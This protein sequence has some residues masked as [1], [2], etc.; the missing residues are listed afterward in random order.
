MPAKFQKTIDCTLNGLTKI[1]CFLD[2]ILK[3][4]RGRIEVHLHLVRKCL[5]KLDE[6]DLRVNI[7]KSHFAKDQIQWL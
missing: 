4:G 2:D 7:T 5:I 6:E 1:F 3:L